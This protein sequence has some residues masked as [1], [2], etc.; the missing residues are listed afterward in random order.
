MTLTQLTLLT[1]LGSLVTFWVVGAAGRVKKLRQAMAV[2]WGQLDDLLAQR[3]VAVDA[4]LAHLHQ[5]LAAEA[6]TLQALAAIHATQ[7]EAS[8]AMRSRMGQPEVV[9][10]WTAAEAA[11][12]SPLARL[13][14]LLEQHPE[15][16]A[17]AE[18]QPQVRL[19]TELAARIAYARQGLATAAAA[20]NQAITEP[21]T[22]WLARLLGWREVG[23]G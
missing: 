1:L 6:G 13:M 5:P 16:A 21:P 12:A 8:R 19:L 20:Y 10:A 7:Q 17:A 18:V 4:L 11:L 15:A 23:V 3:G 14:A 2:A 22:C 9:A